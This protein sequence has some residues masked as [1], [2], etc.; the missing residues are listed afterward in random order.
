MLTHQEWMQNPTPPSRV[1]SWAAPMHLR[2][3]HADT[4]RDTGFYL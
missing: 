1:V 4:A 2:R 3:T